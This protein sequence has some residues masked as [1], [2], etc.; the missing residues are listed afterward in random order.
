MKAIRSSYYPAATPNAR[1]SREAQAA[2]FPIFQ[3]HRARMLQNRHD[4]LRLLNRLGVDLPLCEHATSQR[5]LLDFQ[6]LVKLRCR[7][8]V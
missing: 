5:N 7:I 8:R 6:L 2:S 1:F 3:M 4:F